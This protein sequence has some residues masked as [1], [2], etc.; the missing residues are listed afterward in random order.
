MNGDRLFRVFAVIFGLLSFSNFT[1]PFAMTD[2]VGLVFFGERLVGTANWFVAPF[3]GIYLA[4]YAYTLWTKQ[5]IALVLGAI[6]AV[7]VTLN[8]WLFRV[9]SPE[10]V[11]VNSLYGVTYILIALGVS[12]SAVI[13]LLRRPRDL[14]RIDPTR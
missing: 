14:R 10:L 7:Y 13:F 2:E 12:W 9:R 4:V 8:V 5:R 11:E 6:Y 1:K 3:F